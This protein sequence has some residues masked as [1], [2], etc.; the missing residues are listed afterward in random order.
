MGGPA[1]RSNRAT[2]TSIARTAT[3]SKFRT[4]PAARLSARKTSAGWTGLGSDCTSCHEDIHRGALNQD[5]ATLSRRGKVEPRPRGSTT[6]PPSFPLADKHATVRC[7]KCHLAPRLTPK[8]DGQGHPVPVY[9]P[10]PHQALHRLPHRRAQGPV[11]PDLHALPYHARV[12]ARST[13]S[14]FDHEQD[15]VSARGQA[16]Q[17]SAAPP[18]TRLLH[19]RAQEAARSRPAAP[20]TRTP[21]TARRRS[22]AGWWT[23]TSATRSPASP[24][25]PSRWTQ[26]RH[27]QVSARRASTRR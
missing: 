10:V 2:P 4:S 5:C 14:N 6:T 3:P 7:E 13:E 27:H 15:Q 17:V 24:P 25:P 21:T 20:A 18:A 1:G 26:H 12:A 16:R 23:V 19:A 8:R 11:R 9:K 22:R